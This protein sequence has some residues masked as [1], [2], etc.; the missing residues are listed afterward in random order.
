MKKVLAVLV[1]H[2]EE[3]I[4]YLSQVVSELKSFKNYKFLL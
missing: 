4:D 2:G 3:Q 1:N